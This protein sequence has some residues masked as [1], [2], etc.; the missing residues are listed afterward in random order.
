[1]MGAENVMVIVLSG[2]M[3]AGIPLL[4][5]GVRWAVKTGIEQQ[6]D[7][8]LN[9]QDSKLDRIEKEV[10]GLKRWTEG[11]DRQHRRLIASLERQNIDPPDG[12]KDEA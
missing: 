12:W 11:H 9:R 3:M 4:V 5:T 8:Q 10:H 2:V 7:G 6:V 1:M